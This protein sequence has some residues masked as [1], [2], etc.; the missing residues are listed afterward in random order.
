MIRVV[1][2]RARRADGTWVYTDASVTLTTFWQQVEAGQ[3]TAVGQYTGLRDTEGHPIYEGDLCRYRSDAG[4]MPYE[5]LG[6]I[7]WTSGCFAFGNTPLCEFACV[8]DRL[9]LTIIGNEI[10]QAAVLASA[11]RSGVVH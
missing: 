7:H 10:D 3:L 8:N 11:A 6:V 5:E 1:H 9:P 4:G 2:F